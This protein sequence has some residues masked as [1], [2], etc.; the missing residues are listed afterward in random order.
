MARSEQPSLLDLN[1]QPRA[2]PVR[3]EI[4]RLNAG[5]SRVLAYLMEREGQWIDTW[6]LIMD[7]Q[8]GSR[9]PA[10]CWE[11]QKRGHPIERKHRESGRWCWRYQ[12]VTVETHDKR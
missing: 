4:D 10:R 2:N 3:A 11:L 12:P 6:E 5:Q 9:A 7:A 1:P 8:G